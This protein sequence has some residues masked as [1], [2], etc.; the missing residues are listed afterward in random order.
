MG[1]G[2]R[3]LLRPPLLLPE[4]ALYLLYQLDGSYGPSAEPTPSEFKGDLGD[5]DTRAAGVMFV[6]LRHPNGFVR[7]DFS[8]FTA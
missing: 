4:L 3:E 5:S 1:T 2:L 6:V 8:A 7:T